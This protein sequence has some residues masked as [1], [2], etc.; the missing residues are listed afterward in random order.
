MSAAKLVP[1]DK[2]KECERQFLALAVDVAEMRTHW[3]PRTSHGL[4]VLPL[5]ASDATNLR[6]TLGCQNFHRS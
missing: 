2:R 5:D 3:D 6:T 4:I 1:P